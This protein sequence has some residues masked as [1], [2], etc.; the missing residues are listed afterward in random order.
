MFNPKKLLKTSVSALLI[1]AI[2]PL[3]SHASA[4]VEAEN[5]RVNLIATIDDDPAMENVDWTVY[6]N[7]SDE[8]YKVARKHST[9]VNMPRGVYKVVARLTADDKTVIRTRNFHVRNDTQVVVPMD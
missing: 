5:F 3:S 4:E 8:E 9:H 1:S 2:I 7:N 6:R